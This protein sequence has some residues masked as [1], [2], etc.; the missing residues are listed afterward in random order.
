MKVKINNNKG[1]P[2][3]KII[4]GL[5]QFISESSRKNNNNKK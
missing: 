3:N 2:Y 5:I 1:K 4:K